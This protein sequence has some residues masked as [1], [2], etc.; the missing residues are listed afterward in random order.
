MSGSGSPLSKSPVGSVQVSGERQKVRI[1]LPICV[2][3]SLSVVFLTVFSLTYNKTAWWGE[4]VVGL[5]SS[6][7][8]KVLS[9]KGGM[10]ASV[11]NA[12]TGIMV[13][14]TVRRLR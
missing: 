1:R 13:D 4:P 6:K 5:R 7:G 3:I 8:V 10:L 12:T 11:E 14:A 9:R 2:C